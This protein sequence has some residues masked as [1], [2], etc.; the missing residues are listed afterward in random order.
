M[1][2]LKC[3]T[4]PD[5]TERLQR[6]DAAIALAQKTDVRV[7]AADAEDWLR[8]KL[9]ERPQFGPTIV[10]HSVFLIYPPREKIEAIQA[11]IAQAGAEA[12]EQ[13]P[14]A[15]LCYESEA[16]FGGDKTSPMMYAR[17]QTWPGG[18]VR[19]IAKSDGHVTRVEALDP[20][21]HVTLT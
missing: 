7:D 3:Y 4:W 2:R 19:W 9:A 12:T 5:Q 20:S 13:R 6:L 21:V 8:R 16:L 14:F 18:R 1:L 15:W 10:F 11:L 17:L